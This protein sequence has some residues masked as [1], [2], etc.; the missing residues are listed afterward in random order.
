MQI[1]VQCILPRSNNEI[2][3]SALLRN[4]VRCDFEEHLYWTAKT[5]TYD[6]TPDLSLGTC[7]V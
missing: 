3:I 7:Y 1:V 6:E 5:T 4:K 2:N